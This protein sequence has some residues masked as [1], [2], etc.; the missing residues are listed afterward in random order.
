MVAR[1]AGRSDRRW[2]EQTRP[3][4]LNASDICWWCGP[5][6]S[7]AVDHWDE[8]LSVNRDRANDPTNL[9]PIHGRE[10]CPYCPTRNGKRRVCNNERGNKVGAVP[11]VTGSRPW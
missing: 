8:P 11:P 3:A 5:P 2:K 7:N 9:L 10:G 6:G 1:T 4:V